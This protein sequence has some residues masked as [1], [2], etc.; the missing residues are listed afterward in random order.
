MNDTKSPRGPSLERPLAQSL[1]ITIDEAAVQ[2]MWSGIERRLPRQKMS[3]PARGLWLAF[4]ALLV[5][6]VA[7][8]G[9]VRLAPSDHGAE[10]RALLLAD[11]RAF[12]SIENGIARFADGSRIEAEPGARVEALASTPGELALLVRRGRA[13]FVVTP[14]GPRRWSIDARGVRVEVVG[15]VLSVEASERVVRVGVEVGVVLV[16][17]SLL[18]DGVRRL[19]AGQDVELALERAAREPVEPALSELPITGPLVSEPLEQPAPSPSTAPART[20]RSRAAARRSPPTPAVPSSQPSDA[21]RELWARADAARAASQPELAI[22]L[23]E[24]LLREH[25]D[26][27]QAPLGAFT[28]GT[29]LAEQREPERAVR[30]FRRALEL[31]LPSVLR[32]LCLRRLQELESE[33]MPRGGAGVPR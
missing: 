5:A 25:P 6:V 28:L 24:Q 26:D 4:G 9:A 8:L 13:R 31:G 7:W 22:E 30:A 29:V 32:D 23:L 12:E 20:T 2:R 19:T 10:P 21:A 16:R 17:S 11:G 33:N 18:P 15:T 14:G 3:R 27:A 1:R